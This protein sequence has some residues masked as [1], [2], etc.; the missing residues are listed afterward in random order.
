MK[1]DF[2]SIISFLLAVCLLCLCPGFAMGETTVVTEKRSAKKIIQEMVTTYGAYDEQARPAVEAL[3]KELDSVY[4]DAALR[5]ERIIECW[6]SVNSGLVIH[7]GI[8]P[9]G[10]PDTDAL[11]IVV[12]GY[13]LNGDGTMRKELI[14]RLET[15]LKCAEKYP[16]AF[17]LCTG[18]GTA[19]LDASATEA[20]KMA[21]WLTEN[22]IDGKRILIE[23]KS[24]TTAQNARF[25]YRLL[26]E[27][28]PQVSQIAIVSS[29]YH[30]AAGALLFD[31]EAILRAEQPGQEKMT[32]VSNAAYPVPS[33][34]LSST[35]QAGAL[36]E[37]YGDMLTAL[38]LYTETY[39]VPEMPAEE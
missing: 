24:L 17:I 7:E 13:Q 22:G 5:W 20:G 39:P 15:A 18:G 34:Y 3:L 26:T 6:K 1:K 2:S 37:L 28:Y 14:G 35:F 31:A 21:E 32:V 4:P 30:I 8:L 9:N 38:Q 19:Y 36:M 10:L 33:G 16:N 25:S 12:L 11:C 23:N 29:D 27:N